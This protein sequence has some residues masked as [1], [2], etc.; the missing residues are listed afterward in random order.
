MKKKK[1]DDRPVFSCR[2]GKEQQA[3]ILA[4]DRLAKVSG[5][6]PSIARALEQMMADLGFGASGYGDN[7]ISEKSNTKNSLSRRLK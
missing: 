6:R 7:D 4:F 5:R 1:V 3:F 2:L